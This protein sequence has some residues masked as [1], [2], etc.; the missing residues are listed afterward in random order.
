MKAA[1]EKAD[2]RIEAREIFETRPV[3]AALARMA[4]P[5]IVSQL[6]T[7]IYNIAE[8]NA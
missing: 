1:D 8:M 7:L 5:T 3:P 4:V 6:I 2:N